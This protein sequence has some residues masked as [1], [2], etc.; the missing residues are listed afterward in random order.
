[1]ENTHFV[2]HSSVGEYDKNVYKLEKV[3]LRLIGCIDVTHWNY[4][5]SILDV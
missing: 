1:M 5:C 3:I 4:R 2:S